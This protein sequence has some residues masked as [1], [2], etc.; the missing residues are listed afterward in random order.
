M[1]TSPPENTVFMLDMNGNVVHQWGNPD[2]SGF[3]PIGEVVKPAPYG[4]IL[5]YL[6]VDPSDSK[7]RRIVELNYDGEIVWEYFNPD[8]PTLNHDFQRLP[9]GHLLLLGSRLIDAPAIAPG[10][11]KDDVIFEVNKNKQIVWW[12]STVEHFD[13]LGLSDET[14]QIIASG[15]IVPQ[16]NEADIFHTNAIQSLPPNPI[17]ASDYRFSKGNI[18]VSQRNTNL[19]YVID[20]ASGDIVWRMSGK[21]IGQH[22]VKMIP[23]WLPGGGDI[24]IFDN[25]GWAGYPRQYRFN[26]RV[27][28]VDPRD[29]SIVWKYD[30]TDS[31]APKRSFFSPFRSSAQRMPNGDTVIAESE[32]GR[33]F[34]VTKDGKI[35]WEYVNPYF[36]PNGKFTNR[37]YRGLRF[38]AEWLTSDNYKYWW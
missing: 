21:T 6:R 38:S 36:T 20:K 26:S 32:W 25:G 33:I 30:A 23:W 35:V 1:Y 16:N 27:I 2:G 9:D 15:E 37:I 10:P 24:L 18:L 12:W 19:I 7:R 3:L 22:H 34:E 31:Q 11:V 8:V 29:E 13:Q 5:T 14:K 28:E 17:A 4:G